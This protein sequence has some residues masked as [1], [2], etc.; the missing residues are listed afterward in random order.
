[1]ISSAWAFIASRPPQRASGVKVALQGVEGLPEDGAIL[2]V[3]QVDAAVA[4]HVVERAGIAFFVSEAAEEL[5][6]GM[7]ADG[8]HAA[9]DG[10]F[11]SN[12][13][14]QRQQLANLHAGNGGLDRL[15]LA[16][17]VVAQVRLHVVGVEVRRPAAQEDHDGG[18]LPA[19][20]PGFRLPTQ[21]V[22][23]R[24]T[25]QGQGADGQEIAPGDAVAEAVAGAEEVEHDALKGGG[26]VGFNE[27]G[28]CF[29]A[30]SR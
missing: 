16:A 14:L 29:A 13:R 5:V 26:W 18:L 11:V 7:V 12:L 17:V 19:R 24:Q 10:D 9:E 6:A 21:H 20:R 22:W 27:A 4:P 28:I 1:M 30:T 8:M 15:E 25:A 2:K 3:G 23:Q